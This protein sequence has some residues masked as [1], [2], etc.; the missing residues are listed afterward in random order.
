MDK[1]A[2]KRGIQFDYLL[3]DACERFSAVIDG[4]PRFYGCI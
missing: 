1:Y 2:I 3:A 4:N